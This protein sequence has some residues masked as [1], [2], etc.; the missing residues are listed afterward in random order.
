[1][2]L[3]PVNYVVGDE[4]ALVLIEP[5]AQS[6]HQLAGAH[7]RERERK[8][9]HVAAGLHWPIE[10]QIKNESQSPFLKGAGSGPFQ[11]WRTRLLIVR[12]K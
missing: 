11:I 10:E 3:Q 9:E 12:G 2:L 5:L 7:E 6:S 1:M 8:P 4:V